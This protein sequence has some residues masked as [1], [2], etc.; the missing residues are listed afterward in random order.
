MDSK[1][2]VVVV[3]FSHP[4][5]G[6]FC[7]IDFTIFFVVCFI[8]IIYKNEVKI[9]V[10]NSW[11]GWLLGRDVWVCLFVS[12]YASFNKYIKSKSLNHHG[13]CALFFFVIY[14]IF[15]FLIMYRAG[16]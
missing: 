2:T 1:K 13:P 15:L 6:F 3:L 7:F 8:F 12:E 9:V 5:W 10:D 14:S 11:V 16:C 4:F